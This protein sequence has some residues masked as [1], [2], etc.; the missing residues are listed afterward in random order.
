MLDR[1]NIVTRCILLILASFIVYYSSPLYLITLFLYTFIYLYKSNKKYLIILFISLIFYYFNLITLFKISILISFL[2]SLILSFSFNDKYFIFSKIL[3]NKKAL[4]IIY[5]DRNKTEIKYINRLN[6][7]NNI[8][9]I[10]TYFKRED[11][12]SISLFLLYLLVVIL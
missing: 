4:E 11:I 2:L 12:L 1:V 8:N 10:N 9:K 6:K 7:F 5:K 3:G